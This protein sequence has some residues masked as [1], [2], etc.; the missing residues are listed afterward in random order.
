MVTQAYA[1]TAIMG[2]LVL[3]IAVGL[4][5]AA[6]RRTRPE[7]AEDP[8]DT[9]AKRLSAASENPAVL[10]A[11]FLLVALLAGLV[12][13]AAVGGFGLPEGTAVSLFSATLAVLGLVVAAFLF[14]GP[15]VVTRQHGLGNAHGVAAGITG[16]GFAFLAL[17]AAQLL[18]GVV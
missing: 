6:N 7:D 18:I 15:Y 16:L 8:D 3:A 11:V 12:T 2:L 10:G 4:S 17:V 9:A 5:R 13:V 14:L 1:S